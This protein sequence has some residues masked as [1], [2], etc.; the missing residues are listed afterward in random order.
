MRQ[1]AYMMQQW[2]C[3]MGNK[4]SVSSAEQDAFDRT[5]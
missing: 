4:E 5:S 2:F 3:R 1:S